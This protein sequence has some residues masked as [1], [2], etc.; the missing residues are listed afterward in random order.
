MEKPKQ[1]LF[2]RIFSK[3][4][5]VRIKGEFI[6]MFGKKPHHKPELPVTPAEMSK[7]EDEGFSLVEPDENRNYET[8]QQMVG[9]TDRE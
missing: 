5:A 6:D 2:K 1:S 9:A 7:H 3:E 4:T 8:E